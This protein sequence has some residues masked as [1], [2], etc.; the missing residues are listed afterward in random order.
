[1]RLLAALTFPITLGL[2][3]S[4]ALAAAQQTG[5]LA[6]AKSFEAASIKPASRN[7][8]DFG[9]D[10]DP[11]LLRVEAQ[12]LHDMVRIAYGL[13]DS[14]VTG[15]PKW[16]ESD[17]FDVIGRANGRAGDKELLAM[18]QT[19]LADRFKLVIHRET[20]TVPGFALLVAKG[21]VKMQKSESAESNS[22][23]GRGRI[24]A[25]GYSMQQLAERL[26]RVVRAPVED[27]TETTGAFNFTLNWSPEDRAARP[28]AADRPPGESNA[29]SIF[30]ALEEQL[31]VRLEARKVTIEFIIVDSA[32]KPG[33]N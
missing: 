9:V 17:R 15:G 28:Q 3:G 26:T 10:T 8:T 7:A 21:G 5:N 16:A 30:T 18:F 31:G 13:N 33:E 23:G 2:P 32:E 1:M 14:Q 11:G 29:P 22:R 12:T 24:D 6:A 4:T 25:Q 20:R 19:L 27:A